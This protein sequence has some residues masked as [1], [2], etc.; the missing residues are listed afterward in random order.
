M[1]A[2]G[3]QQHG[4]TGA[5]ASKQGPLHTSR[6]WPHSATHSPRCTLQLLL[7]WW[8]L[9]TPQSLAS[10]HPV[11]S[12]S[13]GHTQTPQLK[14]LQ[15]PRQGWPDAST[16]APA[17]DEEDEGLHKCGGHQH[18]Q[19]ARYVSPMHALLLHSLSFNFP[20]LPLRHIMFP[21]QM[22][23]AWDAHC[24]HYLSTQGHS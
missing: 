2:G 4:D 22:L 13:L 17:L 24:F 19:K 15:C 9:G 23:T 14:P 21:R 8:V 5:M 1:V 3:E 12:H 7:A 20:C 11:I 18:P 10:G 16:A 6:S